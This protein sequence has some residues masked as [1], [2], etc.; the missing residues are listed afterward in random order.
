MSGPIKTILLVVSGFTAL[1]VLAAVALFLFV[2][3]EVYRSRI[4][5]AVSEALGM[6]A[7]FGRLRIGIFPGMHVTL[8]DVHIRNMEAEIVSAEKASLGIDLL[9]LLFR[10]VRIRS[11]VLEQPGIIIERDRDGKYNFERPDADRAASSGLDIPKV[12]LTN[13][14]FLYTDQRSGRKVEAAECNLDLRGLHLTRGNDTDYLKNLSLTGELSCEEA[15]IN[16]LAGSELKITADGNAGVFDLK[17]VTLQIFGAQGSGSIRA[18]F[19]GDVPLYHIRYSLPQFQIGEFINLLSPQQVVEGTMDFSMNLSMQ[20]K[21]EKGMKQTMNG[22]VALHGGNLTL[23]GRDLDQDFARYESTQNFNLVDVGAFFF[24]GPAGLALTKGYK[25]AS[26]FQGSGGSTKINRV[27]SDWKVEGGS[28]LAEDVAMATEENRV[29]LQGRLDFV[30]ERFDD[31][32]VALIDAGGCVKVN[33]TMH[34]TFQEPVVER[35]T[36]LESLTGPARELF[37]MGK[38]LITGEECEVFYDGSVAAP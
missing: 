35:P 38:D 14:A 16:D 27:V 1:L 13:A 4:E 2:D 22:Q 30:N 19:S 8:N 34:G 17:P 20:G 33:Q 32:T 15:R 5:A 12:S 3:T 24:A 23:L 11:I 37:M 31:V 29:A 28:A 9:P 21:S 7:G 10:E 6:E 36:V 18:D 26:L 25:F